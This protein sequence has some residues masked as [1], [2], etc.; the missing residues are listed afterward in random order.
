MTFPVWRSPDASD[1][2][3]L[4]KLPDICLQPS[5]VSVKLCKE[6]SNAS[7]RFRHPVQ[8]ETTFFDFDGLWKGQ[9]DVE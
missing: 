3:C 4:G 8:V 2:V 9:A 7:E 5:N 1:A 6:G